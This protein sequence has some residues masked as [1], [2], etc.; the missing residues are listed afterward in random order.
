MDKPNTTKFP[1]K[2]RELFK[3]SGPD[4]LLINVLFG[5]LTKEKE[6]PKQ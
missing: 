1:L 3:Q 4:E 6:E 5:G 2:L